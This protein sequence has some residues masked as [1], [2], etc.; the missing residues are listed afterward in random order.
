TYLNTSWGTLSS[1]VYAWV[2]LDESGRLDKVTGLYSFRYRDYSPTLGRW[3][4]S[5]P[6]TYQAGDVNL[7]RYVAD[8]PNTNVDPSGLLPNL[9]FHGFKHLQE[10]EM[11]EVLRAAEERIKKAYDSIANHWSEIE[12]KYR[13]IE[14]TDANGQLKRIERQRYKD[15]ARWR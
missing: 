5:D 15:L 9:E 4:Q 8:A 12:E 3:T 14:L 1:S 11:L 7:Y 2:Y 6:L 13:Y 10:M